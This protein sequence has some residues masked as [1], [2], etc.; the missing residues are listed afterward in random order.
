MNI[1]RELGEDNSSNCVGLEKQRRANKSINK[2]KDDKNSV[3]TDQSK[4][5]HMIKEYYEKISTTKP[6]KELLENYIFETNLERNLSAEGF[7]ICDGK[8]TI[9]ECTSAINIM[10]LNK[11]SGLDGL[12]VQFYLAFWDKIK[13]FLV[14]ILNKS[15]N[16][17]F[18]TYSQRTS[19]LSL[20]YY[21]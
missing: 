17:K 5:L 15:Q 2:L 6:N 19:V 21:Y 3:I 9:M 12:T 20:I 11:S 1:D 13:C 4:L 14:D 8:L 10:K 18:L 16:E 7:K